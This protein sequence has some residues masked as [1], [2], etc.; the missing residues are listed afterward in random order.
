MD[1][2]S[3]LVTGALIGLS[4]AAPIGPLGVLCINRTLSEGVFTGLCT[5][6]GGATVQIGYT[7]VLLLGFRE[8]GAWLE[9]NSQ[10][11]NL[12]GAVLM[13]A[14]AVRL[15]RARRPPQTGRVRKVGSLLVAYLSAVLFNLT[16]PMTV[17]L[18]VGAMASVFGQTLPTPGNIAW[19]LAGQFAGA[20]AWWL[21]LS[22]TTALLRKRL[23]TGAA[24]LVNK[25]AAAVLIGFGCLPFARLLLR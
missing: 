1:I 20:A 25:A 8:F 19:L 21:L 4:V 2:L 12:G 6:L 18:L 5:G 7:G 17:V 15:L 13:L 10:V 22:G 23:S 16:N 14:F 9:G 24:L 11:M 3:L